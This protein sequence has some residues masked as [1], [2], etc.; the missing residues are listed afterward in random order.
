M[1]VG[2]QLREAREARGLTL[3]QVAATTRVHAR[4]LDGIE[5]NDLSAMPPRPYARG[6]I[7]AYAREVGLNP[8]ETVRS[9]FAQFA[10]VSPPPELPEPHRTVF[11]VEGDRWR[12]WGPVIALVAIVV[13][14]VTF[15][16]PRVRQAPERAADAVVGTTGTVPSGD[17]ATGAG[18]Q[19]LP[20]GK[21]SDARHAGSAPAASIPT[22]AAGAALLVTLETAGPSWISAT[23]D[24]TRQIYEVVP[25]GS[26]RTL[27][28]SREVLLRVGDAGAVR[29]SVNGGAPVL[30]GNRGEVRNV[31]LTAADAR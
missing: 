14:A 29:W 7:A 28:A 19:T 12:A 13:V 17:P 3:A 15:A 11:P 21:P 20:A 30:M 26:R 16:A 4:V 10:E 1:N 5:R 18:V 23:V 6:F 22:T 25:P 31:R 27:R 9:Y 8:D 24:G 2:T